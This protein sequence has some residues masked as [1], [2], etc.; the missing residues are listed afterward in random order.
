MA[1]NPRITTI[2]NPLRSRPVPVECQQ[3]RESATADVP[4][5]VSPIENDPQDEWL[6]ELEERWR[7]NWVGDSERLLPHRPCMEVHHA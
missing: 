1:G 3:E 2:A 5:E 7:T 4:R 6:T